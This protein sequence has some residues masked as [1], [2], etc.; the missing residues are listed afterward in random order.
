MLIVWSTELHLL[1]D[2]HSSESNLLKDADK[3]QDLLDQLPGLI[4]MVKISKPFVVE[5]TDGISKIDWG[6]TG[7]V[8]IAESHISIHTFPERNYV[9]IDVFSCKE[10]DYTNVAD[11][12]AGAFRLVEY[13]VTV[14]ERGIEYLNRSTDD[15]P[16]IR[17]SFN[18]SENGR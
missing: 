7:F 10:F 13:N 5:Y 17:Q 18:S 15:L 11:K 8:L 4:D 12:V 16:V 9:N 1:V 2:G 14:L 3:I 6:I